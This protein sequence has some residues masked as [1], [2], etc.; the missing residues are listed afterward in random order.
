MDDGRLSGG[1]FLLDGDRAGAKDLRLTGCDG[2]EEDRLWSAFQRS[3]GTKAAGEE[4]R[5]L[6]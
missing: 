2:G 4:D 3:P 1:V 5:S 6:C